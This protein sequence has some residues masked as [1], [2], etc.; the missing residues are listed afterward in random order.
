MDKGS[1]RIRFVCFA[2]FLEF[3]SHISR[4]SVSTFVM[5]KFFPHQMTFHA[6]HTQ[7]R[8]NK[9]TGQRK[10]LVKNRAEEYLVKKNRA[11]ENLVKKTGQRKT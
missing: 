3:F 9:K 2:L 4:P 5:L 1:V 6:V 7:H 11:E 8:L 10:N